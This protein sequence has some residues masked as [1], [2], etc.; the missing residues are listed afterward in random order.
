MKALKSV[1]TIRPQ[2]WMTQ[3]E[4]CAVMDAL[5][6]E[7]GKALFVGGCVRNALLEEAV[8]DIDIA[9]QYVPQQVIQILEERGIRVLP[10]GIDHGTVTAIVKGKPFEITSLRRDVE[11]D[12]R[13]AVVSFTQ[14][15]VEDAH[16]RDFTINTL[17]ADQKGCIYDPL[18][19]GLADLEERRVV[20]V[21]RARQRIAE[22][23]LRILRF[24]RFHGAYGRGAPDYDALNACR[25]FADKIA[26][27]SRERVT[28]EFF[29]IMALD[30]PVATLSLMFENN[31]LKTFSFPEYDSD[32]LENFCAFQ[33]R[34][35][36]CFVAARLLVLAGFK[37]KNV[38]VLEEALL[39]PK[40]FQKDIKAISEVL[41]LEDLSNAQAV[42]VA[43]YKHGRV[44]SAQALLI[45]LVQDRVINGY[46]PVALDIIQN[47][48]VPDFPVSGETLIRAGYEPGPALGQKLEE[49]EEAWIQSGFKEIGEPL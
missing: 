29:K 20:F 31:V 42:K 16:R 18:G 44:A 28:Q 21:G 8:E 36:L 12:G 1:K 30:N 33:E 40:V 9:T 37:T 17:L 48:D 24:F 19:K 47:W 34:Y 5:G 11:T 13:H 25:E 43:I 14:D 49:M 2:V 23:V 32:L 6:S 10:T 39:I 45:E 3:P 46:A 15:W 41:A 7:G 27:L 35:G 26:D 22:D 4:T 38:K